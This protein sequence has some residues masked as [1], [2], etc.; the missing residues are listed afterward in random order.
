MEHRGLKKKFISEM[1][2]GSTGFRLYETKDGGQIEISVDGKVIKII[3]GI[4]KGKND[5]SG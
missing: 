5:F 2:I 1:V 4:K 3:K